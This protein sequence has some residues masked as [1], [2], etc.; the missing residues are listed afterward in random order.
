MLSEKQFLK[1]SRSLGL[2]EVA[3]RT[4]YLGA[5]QVISEGHQD[6]PNWDKIFAIHDQ[7]LW[8]V[9]RSLGDR[10]LNIYDGAEEGDV[11]MFINSISDEIR[12]RNEK[13][14]KD[15]NDFRDYMRMLLRDRVKFLEAILEVTPD[16]IAHFKSGSRWAKWL[17]TGGAVIITAG[18]IGKTIAFKSNGKLEK[19]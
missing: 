18:I 15:G 7:S 14:T 10:T 19:K 4:F 3:L 9:L 13:A 1:D 17:L 8:Q 11:T 2:T 12:L 16:D 5:I 6:K